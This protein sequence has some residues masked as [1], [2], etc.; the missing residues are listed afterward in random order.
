MLDVLIFVYDRYNARW[1][2]LLHNRNHT[3]H[4]DISN[5]ENNFVLLRG[6]ENPLNPLRMYATAYRDPGSILVRDPGYR[7][8][9]VTGA[10]EGPLR[11][12]CCICVCVCVHFTRSR[13]WRKHM[14][15]TWWSRSSP[16]IVSAR[17][18]SCDEWYARPQ[19][20][21][22]SPAEHNIRSRDYCVRI[23]RKSETSNRQMKTERTSF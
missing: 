15:N 20:G 2:S 5:S 4:R 9:P 8:S 13:I 21:H 18:A 1:N 22:Y 19:N 3:R 10:A 17:R 14:Y 12:F 7:R 6:D 23:W 11:S 16:S